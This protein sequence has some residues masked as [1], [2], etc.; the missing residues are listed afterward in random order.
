MMGLGS[1]DF[2][3]LGMIIWHYHR[4]HHRL[5]RLGH[6]VFSFRNHVPRGFL[7]FKADPQNSTRDRAISPDKHLDLHRASSNRS[8]HAANTLKRMGFEKV[9]HVAGGFPALKPAGGPSEVV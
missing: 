1:G 6:D 2:W 8:A 9:S 5:H 3:P 4:G 7:E